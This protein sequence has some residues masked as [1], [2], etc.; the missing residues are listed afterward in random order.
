MRSMMMQMMVKMTSESVK[1]DDGLQLTLTMVEVHS[2]RARARAA[3]TPAIVVEHPIIVS[4]L[5]TAVANRIP[6]RRANR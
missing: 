2:S 3:K 6:T 5:E 1:D 4:P